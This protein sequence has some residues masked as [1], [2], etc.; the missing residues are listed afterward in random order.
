MKQPDMVNAI[1]LELKPLDDIDPDLQD[2]VRLA[3]R[4]E[5]GKKK[6]IGG[7]I[8]VW[9]LYDDGGTFID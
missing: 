6:Y 5:S 8:H 3:E 2:R 7:E 1:P 9:W 4:F